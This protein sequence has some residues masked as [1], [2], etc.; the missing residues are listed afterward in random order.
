MAFAVLKETEQNIKSIKSVKRMRP[1]PQSNA[2]EMSHL[3][4]RYE[5]WIVGKLNHSNQAPVIQAKQDYQR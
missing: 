5:H 1:R 3:D 2:K 4:L